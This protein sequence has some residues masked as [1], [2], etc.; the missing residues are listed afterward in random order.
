MAR[1]AQ[2]ELLKDLILQAGAA[3]LYIAAEKRRGLFRP[4][5]FFQDRPASFPFLL[6]EDRSVTRAYGIYHLIGTDALNIA[7]PSTFVVERTGIIRFLV[8]GENQRERAP[9][10]D[11]LEAVRKL[12]P[13][14]QEPNCRL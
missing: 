4:E 8:V 5:K 12:R 13:A 1:M 3:L 6:D 11:V 10:A 2:F 14:N 7:R 9:I